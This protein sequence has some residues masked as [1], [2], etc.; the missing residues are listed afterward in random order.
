[1]L[2]FFVIL[3]I[4]FVLTYDPK[5]RTLDKFI[6]SPE[7]KPSCCSTTEYRADNPVQCEPLYYQGLQFANTDLGCPTRRPSVNM[8]AIV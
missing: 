8:G 3:A 2:R 6:N 7:K 1:M 4:I 5:S